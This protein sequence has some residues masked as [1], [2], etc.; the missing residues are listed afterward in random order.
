M[1]NNLKN[2]PREFSLMPFWFWNDHLTEAELLRQMDDYIAHG[3]YGF[4]IHPRVG[5]PRSTGFCSKRLLHF[6]RFAVVEAAKRKM[7]VVLYDEGMYPSG[8]ASGLVV[9]NNPAHQCRCYSRQALKRGQKLQLS[10]GQ[11]LVAVVKRVNGQQIAIID[12]PVDAVI[13]GLHYIGNG[14][15]EDE[16]P[17]GDI[18]NPD[19]VRSF[20]NI[21]YDGYYA[22]VGDY[23]G[24]TVIGMFT[25]EPNPLGRCREQGVLPG[26]TGF[27]NEVNRILG[28]DFT[29]H[30][31]ALWY[32]DEPDALRYRQEYQKAVVTRLS[33]I[34]YRPLSEWCAGKNVALMGHPADAM[35][36]GL[37][38]H[39]HV[40][41]QDTVWRWVLPK[42]PNGLEG[43][44][45]TQAKCSSSAMIHLGRRRNSN[46]CYGA[47]GHE[48]TWEEMKTLADWLF[49]R[50]VN[51]LLPHAFYY[52][53][54]G[55]RRDERP[56][57]VGPN[58]PW[59]GQYRDFAGYCAS[60]SWLNTDCSHVCQL[61]ILAG[62][63]FLPWQVAKIC[64]QHQRDFNY[65]ESRHLLEDAI[66]DETGIHIRG[67]HYKF[68]I[69][70]ESVELN[71]KILP[72]LLMLKKSGRM[73]RFSSKTTPLQ[74]INAID[75]KISPDFSITPPLT[76]LR[77][78]HVVKERI[79]YYLLTNEGNVAIEFIPS[80]SAPG[81]IRIIDLLA[82]KTKA[83]LRG[84][85]IR[86]DPVQS[87]I[88]EIHS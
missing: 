16:P 72:V 8:S 66:V 77:Y 82:H 54:R 57:D 56:P 50:G 87:L 70:E 88:A 22:A 30:L 24:S 67:M 28:Y 78:R 3:V 20:I 47:Y 10:N 79:N 6:V 15:E 4:V 11:N 81:N 29:A 85:T 38:R 41:G 61:A 43:A 7:A 58:S 76:E 27:L 23:F 40:P 26:T 5:L 14:P 35:S 46:E 19:A 75:E 25:D 60:L 17:A 51:Q 18:L 83:Y 55:P 12:R 39:F 59:W 33:E 74:L 84:Q 34:Y 13:R 86:L 9:K 1:V 71:L 73:M 65:L 48:L 31:P 21:V 45:S 53:V 69:V 44:E 36:I 63:E 62:E 49:V 2:P 64:F 37:E 42:E 80:F 52:S 68:L 32:D